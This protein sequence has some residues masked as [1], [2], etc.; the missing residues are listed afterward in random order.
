[1]I[2]NKKYITAVLVALFILNLGGCNGRPLKKRPK[3]VQVVYRFDE[4]RWLELHGIACE[5][6]LWFVDEKRAIRSEVSSQFYRIFTKPY[7]NASER[8]IAVP[9]WNSAHFTISR[10]YGRTWRP[11][12]IKGREDDE[13][14]SDYPESKNIA[15]L[16]IVNDQ[17]FLLTKQGHLYMS[18]LPFD[19][20]RIMPG[21]SGIDY[22][23]TF[24]GRLYHD[25]QEA[26][27]P[28]KGENVSRWGLFYVDPRILH[29]LVIKHY[30]NFQNLP[31]RVPEVKGYTGWTHMQCDMK[32]GL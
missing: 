12:A 15:S 19:D 17:G 11:S 28:G 22:S 4:H 9:S 25:R 18:S 8:Y 1:M 2:S 27:R 31:T 7:I 32:A 6:A 5:G 23:Y 13:A 20:P 26:I 29:R 21:G 14:G 24:K 10:D 30:A 16:T 3:P